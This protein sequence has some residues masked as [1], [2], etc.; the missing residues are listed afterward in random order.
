MVNR[1][2]KLAIGA[3]VVSGT[4]L[5]LSATR[6][7]GDEI[8]VTIDN[9]NSSEGF[10]FTPVWLSAQNGSFDLY[11][12]G[13]FS[14]PNWP[15][16]TAIA[17]NGNTG[18]LDAA[19]H[20]SGAGMAGGRSLVVT[21]NTIGPPVFNPGESAT[22]MFDIGDPTVNR[23]LSYASMVIPSNDLF[24]GNDNP[25]AH[26]LFDVH[27][28]FNG[29]MEILIFGHMVNDNGTEVNNA[30]GDAAFSLN[31]GQAMP[32]YN[33]IRA[34]FTDPGDAD[35]LASFLGTQTASLDT[36]NSVFGPQD[37]IARIRID[38]IPAPGSLAFLMVG[39][40]AATGRRRRRMM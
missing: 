32:E 23:F 8:R 21:A 15:G 14:Q 16:M 30:Y 24:F 7:L 3:V 22:V 13:T 1:C 31:D 2:T 33:P 27:G 17:E 18:P 9:M 37:V 26:E 10:F 35:Y 34:F 29:P 36:I 40:L 28:N 11:D 19:F 38:Q 5:G 4:I 39:G 20:A 12:R 6:T 25:M